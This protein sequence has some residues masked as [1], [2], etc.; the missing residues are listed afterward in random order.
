[1]IIIRGCRLMDADRD[2]CLLSFHFLRGIT[3]IFIDTIDLHLTMR[4]CIKRNRFLVFAR[5][6]ALPKESELY[7]IER[8]LSIHL[9][10]IV[11][12]GHEARRHR[13]RRAAFM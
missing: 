6:R 3:A 11:V 2:R 10:I 4:M 1:M 7:V 12:N 13:C 5:Q 8:T 9:H